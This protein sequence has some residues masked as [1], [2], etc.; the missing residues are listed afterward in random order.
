MVTENG[1]TL[2]GKDNCFTERYDVFSYSM[3][4]RYDVVS[5]S[6]YKLYDVVSYS[7]YKRYDVVSYSMYKRYDVVSYSMYKCVI[8]FYETAHVAMSLLANNYCYLCPLTKSE[9]L[10]K[11]G[12]MRRR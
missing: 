10:I 11:F 9:F 8:R 6:M 1:V 3:Y 7:M 4:K 5:Y 12:T 2:L